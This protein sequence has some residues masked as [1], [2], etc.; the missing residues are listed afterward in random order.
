MDGGATRMAG[1]KIGIRQLVEFVLRAGDL[2]SSSNSQNTALEGARIHRKLQ[3]TGG[4]NYE[5]EVY[6]KR[7]VS[8]AGEDY[9]IDGRADGVIQTNDSLVIEEIKT[10]DPD[11]EDL[12]ENTLTLYWSQVK[13]YGAILTHDLDMPE[14]TLRL[15]Y[16]QRTT[17]KITQNE[18]VYKREDLQDFFDG[19]IEEYRSWLV[20]RSDWRKKRNESIK[21][22]AF[23]F[24]EYRNGQRDLAVA[25]YKTVALKKRLFVEAP[26]GTGKT[27]STLFPAVKAMG[28]GLSDQL[29]YLTAKQSTRSVAEKGIQL[30][31]DKGLQI[32]S[33]TLTAKDKIIFPEEVDV[34]PEDNPYMIGYYDRLKDGIRDVFEHENQI[35]RPTIEKYAK[36]HTLDPFEFSLDISTFMDVIICDYNYL[37][38]PI[39]YLQRFFSQPDDSNFFLVDEAHNLVSRSR[40]MYTAEVDDREIDNLLKAAKNASQNEDVQGI[41]NQLKKVQ[42]VFDQVKL[43]LVEQHKTKAVT[44]E[45]LDSFRHGLEKFNSFVS[46][47]LAKQEPTPFTSQILEFYFILLRYVK[48][49]AF[50]DE[51]YRVIVTLNDDE[52]VSVKELCLDPSPYLDMSLKMG[53]GVVFFSATLSPMDYF[54]E[55]LGCETTGLSLQLTSP[56][57]EQRQNI[58]ITQYVNTTYNQRDKS[59]QSIVTSIFEMVNAKKG[60]YL[61]FCPSYKYMT[62]IENA[63]LDQYQQFNVIEQ[64]NQM[65]ETARKE[66]LD[67]FAKNYPHS[68][69]GF[70]VLGG[71]FSEGIDLVGD[72]LIG[73]A[74]VSVGLPGLSDERNLLRDYFNDKNGK[75]F[76][77]AYQLPGMNHVLQAAGRLIR[78]NEDAG[79]V[80]LMDNRFGSRRYTNLFPRHWQHYQRVYSVDQLGKNIS[81]FWQRLSETKN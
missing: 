40:D 56:F 29:F 24:D 45:E 7:T 70:S 52:S 17:D 59:V 39:V 20:M 2:S 65:D 42:T 15:T 75:G 21:Q 13:V 44:T 35:T 4:E 78:S 62:Q 9:V 55:T 34:A 10:S 60:N 12:S 28:E 32:K 69:I 73:V 25:V 79:N 30:M 54:K 16:Y 72:Y 36:K 51:S 77:Y 64:S 67:A 81:N 47:W 58:L 1:N 61:I 23:P 37:F 31:V 53:R 3:K 38:D 50:Y 22:L 46:D 71:I 80:L 27:I 33:I 5:K 19:L 49:S 74:I 48:I 41:S 68:L 26:T 76:E 18:H 63:F 14:V 6:V 66:F 43:P 57:L 11:F 8:M